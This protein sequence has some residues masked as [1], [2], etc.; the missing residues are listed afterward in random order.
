M[1]VPPT[2]AGYNICLQK[3]NMR[4]C[5]AGVHW[6]APLNETLH[7]I[8]QHGQHGCVP[9]FYKDIAAASGGSGLCR[10]HT[11]GRLRRR[12][13]L[14]IMSPSASI[15]TCLQV[16]AIRHPFC[17]GLS[18][19]ALLTPLILLHLLA[20]TLPLHSAAGEGWATAV[21]SV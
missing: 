14:G 3:G 4:K 7:E 9:Q 15:T 18:I 16:N 11:S 6:H 1:V 13:M 8:L 21:Q 12:L 17:C 20:L 10:G 2:R 19:W 5:H